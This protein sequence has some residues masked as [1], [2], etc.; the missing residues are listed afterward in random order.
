MQSVANA[1]GI[2]KRN[3]NGHC[4]CDR[5][6]YSDGNGSCYGHGNSHSHGN[7]YGYCHPNGDFAAEGYSIT[8]ASWN[9]AAPTVRLADR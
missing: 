7:R 6:G 8:E 2:A 4:D 9:T 1:Y 5:H 3:G